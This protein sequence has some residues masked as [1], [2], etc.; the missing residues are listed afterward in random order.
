MGVEYKKKN[1]FILKGLMLIIAVEP[2]YSRFARDCVAYA[3]DV[4][5]RRTPRVFK[6]QAYVVVAEGEGFEPPWTCALTVFK[7]A[8]L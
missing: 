5:L 1:P 8:P 6:S 3:I 4:S 7:T 2:G